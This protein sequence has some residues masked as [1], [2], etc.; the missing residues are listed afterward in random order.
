MKPPPDPALK[1]KVLAWI[2]PFFLISIA[3]YCKFWDGK[4]ILQDAN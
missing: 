4:L 3:V 2:G 1:E